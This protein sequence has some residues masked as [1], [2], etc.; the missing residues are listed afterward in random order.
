M[1]TAAHGMTRRRQRRR[2]GD[3]AQPLGATGAGRPQRA[4]PRPRSRN[5]WP[6]VRSSGAGRQGQPLD[7]L[8]PKRTPRVGGESTPRIGFRPRDGQPPRNGKAE[9]T[10]RRQQRRRRAPPRPG[11]ATAA[12]VTARNSSKMRP[13]REEQCRSHDATDH[14]PAQ[15]RPLDANS[16]ERETSRN[17][18]TATEIQLKKPHWNENPSASGKPSSARQR[19]PPPRGAAAEPSTTAAR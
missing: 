18:G 19:S 3:P 1:F 10:R 8:K 13:C 16:D 11:V 5:R 15:R 12:P 17:S 7:R 9:R 2:R 14:A 4:A 6:P